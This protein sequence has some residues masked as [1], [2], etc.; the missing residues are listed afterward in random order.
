MENENMKLYERV[1]RVPLEA[2]KTI[3]GGRLNGMT[4]INPMWRIKTLTEEFGACGFGWYPELKR[5]WIEEGAGGQKTANVEIL[6][7][8]KKGTEWSKGIPGIGG[9]ALIAKETAGLYTDDECFKKAY[10]DALSVACKALGI[11]ADVYFERDTTKYDTG[12]SAPAV[13]Q[14]PAEQAAQKKEPV[15]EITPDAVASAGILDPEKMI[16]WLEGKIGCP[17]AM[18]D[19]EE[20]AAAWKIIKRQAAKNAGQAQESV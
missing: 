2:K 16:D 15:P 20:R 8:V 19:D 11:G 5:T 4:D 14:K 6:L 13:A 18:F 7:Y 17:V 12:T 1:R 3:K 10:T 9:S